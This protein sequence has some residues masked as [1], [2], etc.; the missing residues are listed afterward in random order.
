MK[1]MRPINTFLPALLAVC[2][3][4]IY[5][6]A[7]TPAQMQLINPVALGIRINPDGAGLTG[8]FFLC[9]NLVI[10]AQLS[11]SEGYL[12]MPHDGMGYGPSWTGTGLVEY[13]FIFRD[14]SWR[15]YVGAG[16]HAGKWDKYDHSMNADAPMA[17]G[18]FGADAILGVEYLFKA[19]AY[20][21]FS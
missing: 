8:K 6:Q 21:F 5:A 10:E 19:R 9:R 20:R 13:H 15:I 3:S 16:L 7:Q 12:N 1:A 14:P 18:I 17:E 11:G 2:F 4:G